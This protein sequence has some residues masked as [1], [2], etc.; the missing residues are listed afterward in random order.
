MIM[1][2]LFSPSQKNGWVFSLLGCSLRSEEEWFSPTSP[3]QL[4]DGAERCAERGAEE[5]GRS[6]GRSDRF[7]DFGLRRIK[8]LF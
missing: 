6:A 1:F 7:S 3:G 2:I 8:R 4:E 5:I